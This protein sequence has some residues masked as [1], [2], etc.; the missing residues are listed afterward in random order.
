MTCETG[1]C[2]SAESDY[3]ESGN[4]SSS[5]MRMLNTLVSQPVLA[6]FLIQNDSSK[7]SSPQDRTKAYM[8]AIRDMFANCRKNSR[9]GSAEVVCFVV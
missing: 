2:R 8:S 3:V 6:E 7:E 1:S 9:E 4:L 5:G